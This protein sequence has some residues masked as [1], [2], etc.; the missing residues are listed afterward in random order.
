MLSAEEGQ[1]WVA[2]TK[3]TDHHWHL[4]V[5]PGTQQ[6]LRKY[7]CLEAKRGTHSQSQ[8]PV[9]MTM[10]STAPGWPS[11]QN[12]IQFHV[13]PSEMH[14]LGIA[15]CSQHSATQPLLSHCCGQQ[16]NLNSLLLLRA[17]MDSGGEVI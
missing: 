8:D 1:R 15:F 10:F 12:R 11:T 7:V 4:V 6:M 3:A 9:L 2:E 16:G 5:M 14:L 17:Q 13:H